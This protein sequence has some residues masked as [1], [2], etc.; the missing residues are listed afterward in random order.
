MKL[1]WLTVAPLDSPGYR[2]TQ[3]GMAIALEKLGW[4]VHLMGKSSISK[5]FEAFGGFHG[6]V[7]LIRRKGRLV[8]ELRYHISLWRSLLREKV[9]IVLFEPPQ[10]RLMA[11]P[12]LL[13]RVR[14]LKTS[15]ILDVRTPL[16]DEAIDRRI[17]RLNY[18]LA[19]R[20]AK[21]I[22]P[23]ATVI[24]EELRKDLG[25]LLGDNKRLAVWGS[26]VD[27]DL[28]DPSKV[29]SV[30]REQF[31]LKDRFI[32]VYH[33]SVSLKRGLLELIAAMKQLYN[34][35]KMAA[36]IILGDG[37]GK[38]E[39]KDKVRRLELEE[40]V[41]ILGPV[42]NSDVPKYIGM[43]D[44]GVLPLPKDRCWQVSS[45]LKLFEYMAMQLP[46]IASDIVAIR[47]V[48]G[49]SPS[50]VYVKE[51][52][53]EDLYSA[54]KLAIEKQAEL[55]NNAY[56]AREIVEKEHSWSARARV[57]SGFLSGFIR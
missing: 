18:W 41:C 33:G 38:Q 26:G 31:G 21:Y 35:N 22:L 36:L 46:I 17:D 29:T 1:L 34:E 5:V 53:S 4:Q 42:S 40:A 47:S 32:F 20:F 24:T 23:G 48:L 2:T 45:P 52:N 9:D 12:S 49:T 55:K 51:I 37:P 25:H 19:I 39:L 44:V 3:F 8:T 10:L 56:I 15:F 28:F 57:L 7:S 11:I 50:T 54:L 43:A 6:K 27:A 30:L 13:S 14:V 16:V